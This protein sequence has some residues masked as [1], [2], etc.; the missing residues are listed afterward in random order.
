MY[1]DGFVIKGYGVYHEIKLGSY[2]ELDK[3]YLLK[4]DNIIPNPQVNKILDDIYGLII[5]NVS[6]SDLKFS[7]YRA[8]T[9]VDKILPQLKRISFDNKLD[10][11]SGELDWYYVRGR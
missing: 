8:E 1:D 4:E 7:K 10:L 6:P 11:T 9:Y 3:L 5:G 2:F